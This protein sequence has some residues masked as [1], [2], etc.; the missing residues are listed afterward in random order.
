MGTIWEGSSAYDSGLVL[1][2]RVLKINGDPVSTS[3]PCYAAPQLSEYTGSITLS[4]FADNQNRE[5][6]LN[7]RIILDL[8]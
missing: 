4:V 5:V 8:N 7:R 6:R 3:A 2:D 1:G